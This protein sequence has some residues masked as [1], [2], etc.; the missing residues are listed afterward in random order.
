MEGNPYSVLL[1]A[2]RSDTEARLPA[3]FRFGTVLSADP[4]RVEVAGTV[5]DAD[6]LMKNAA[7]TEFSIGDALLLVPIENEQ[8]YIILCKVVGL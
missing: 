3:S 6:D 2:F 5:Q 7:L 8:R 1:R 4:L